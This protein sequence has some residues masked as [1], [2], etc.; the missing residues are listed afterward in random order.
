MPTTGNI[1]AFVG[2]STQADGVGDLLILWNYA[3][4]KPL[5]IQAIGLECDWNFGHDFQQKVTNQWLEKVQTVLDTIDFECEDFWAYL[6]DGPIGPKIIQ[7]STPRE[8]YRIPCDFLWAPRVDITE[9]ETHRFW[10]TGQGLGRGVWRGKKVDI[11]I[12]CD[13][14]DLQLVERTTRSLKAVRGMDV[15][16]DVVAHIFRGNLLIGILTESSH[17][18]LFNPS[19]IYRAIVLVFAAFA[20][21]ERAFFLHE[22]LIDHQRVL[23]DEKGRVRILDLQTLVYYPP[24]E[25]KQFEEK[26]QK[27]HWDRLPIIFDGLG[28]HS[29]PFPPLFFKPASTILVRTP[30]PERV[31]L[32]TLSFTL[33]MPASLSDDE[34]SNH[35]RKKKSTSVRSNA[36]VLQIGS[37]TKASQSQ[38]LARTTQSGSISPDQPPPP[39]SRL[40]LPHN[41]LVYRRLLLASAPAES[42]TVGSGSS[43]VE[44]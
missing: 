44:L 11:L 41:R 19:A 42:T 5:V 36:K 1:T 9:I 18:H 40:P 23:I 27:F 8:H 17:L 16:Y 29:A 14:R 35:R 13:D 32:I 43:I 20:K 15:T 12:G 30:S 25:R 24:H 4:R 33:D 10:C 39:Y 26:A 38:S 28:P 2:R 7:R 34:R 3:Y 31:L 6:I 22:F 21:L 37:L